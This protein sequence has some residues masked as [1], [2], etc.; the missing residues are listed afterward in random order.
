M[1]SDRLVPTAK[2]PT[3]RPG[4]KH[5]LFRTRLGQLLLA[6]CGLRLLG[7]LGVVPP[8]LT[9]VSTIGLWIYVALLLLWAV[10]GLRT[11]LLW[12]IR[13][14]LFIS[15]L[16]IG[17]VPMVLILSFFALT[18]Y[19]TLGQVS[20]YM[21]TAAVDGAETKAANSANLLLSELQARVR[22]GSRPSD[23][24][25]RT[26]LDEHV[27]N[28]GERLPDA[29]AI[30]L[31]HRRGRIQRVVATD[32][33]TTLPSVG[34]NLPEWIATGHQ[35]GIKLGA[36]SYIA[37]ASTPL[38]SSTGATVLVLAPLAAVLDAA[39]TNLGFHIDQL[40]ASVTDEGS[41][42]SV[43][44]RQ[45][46]ATSTEP[47]SGTETG[48]M[49]SFTIPW[50]TLFQVRSFDDPRSEE[51]E[52]VFVQFGF[53]VFNF[54]RSIASGTLQLGPNGPDMGQ[55]LVTAMVFLAVLFLI[56]QVSAIFVGLVLARSIT[57]SVHALSQGTEHVRQGDFSYKVQV[58]SRDQLGELADS[59]NL[60]T[61]SIQDLLRESAEKQRLEEEL[62][63]AR[64]IQMKLLPKDRVEAPG[65]S[66][67]PFCLPATEVGG[68]YYD[69]IPLDDG[70][71]ALLIADVSGK[72][73]SAALYMA[74][75]KGLVLS[76]SQIYHS[77][78]KLLVEADKILSATLDS[79]SFITMVYAVI[80]M[81]ERRMTYARAGHNPIFHLSPNGGGERTAVLAPDGMGLALAR[82]ELFERVLR[83][84]SVE[85]TSGDVF[86]FFTDG[87]SEAMNTRDELFGEERIRAIMEE[88]TDIEM[89][90]L[91][92][93]IVD[94]VFDFAGGAVQHDDMTMVLVKVL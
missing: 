32:G 50:W 26:V 67:A 62:R 56:I 19:F 31:E 28:L 75:L 72:G 38:E 69:F 34:T 86:L 87:V 17:L 79:R 39:A 25:I 13:R 18:G 35:G 21:L 74:E 11:K 24:R 89:D 82:G 65:L 36:S 61:A 15:Y 45:A 84:D 83:E 20:S 40:L 23:D 76:L 49:A 2:H 88:N 48:S 37:G 77:P 63:I 71:L 70:R 80:D 73:T 10:G 91:R 51:P 53:P 64:D 27:A 54:H 78:R 59:F 14:K 42:E 4:W 22:S 81:N 55:L 66:I 5:F 90:E 9:T 30:Y 68:D 6:L 3:P 52:L 58:R 16:L 1:A 47:E 43:F 12:R 94:E 41:T 33:L 29:S 44:E 7:A 57:G 85:F 92:E 60:M 46:E 8:A 93:K